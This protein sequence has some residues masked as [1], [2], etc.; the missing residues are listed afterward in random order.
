MNENEIE[1]ELLKMDFQF[2]CAQIASGRLGFNDL[3]DA[4]EKCRKISENFKKCA[5]TL[6]IEIE[7]PV[8]QDECSREILTLQRIAKIAHYGGLENLSEFRVLIE[9]RK[10]TSSYLP[11]KIAQKWRWRNEND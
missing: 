6:T 2:Y 5:K 10:L 8:K 3:A 4:H 9:I 7:S 1:L 11:E